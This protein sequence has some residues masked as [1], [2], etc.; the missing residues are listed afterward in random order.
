MVG[1]SNG[2]TNLSAIDLYDPQTGQWYANITQLP[3]PRSFAGITS[4]N[5]KIYVTGGILNDGDVTNKTEVFDIATHSWSNGLNFP[6]EIQGLQLFNQDGRIYS[7]GGSTTNTTEAAISKIMRMDVDAGQWFAIYDIGGTAAPIV[8]LDG[9]A[10]VL[11]G[12]MYYA[13]WRIETG[14]IATTYHQYNYLS[15]FVT[16]AVAT[17]FTA[18]RV[19][20][21]C[22]VYTSG[23]KKYIFYSGGIG[24][25][26]I[27]SQPNTAA[28]VN[29]M[30]VYIPPINTTTIYS[31]GTM[32]TARA[33]HGSVVWGTTL[34]VF[35]G[36]N[37]G[38]T[39][40]S[41][42]YMNTINGVTPETNWPTKTWS[43]GSSSMPNKRFGF[44]A[45]TIY[46]Q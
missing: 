40:D 25:S 46:G 2:T 27:T 43:S 14:G 39:Y 37:A 26:L 23:L 16:N 7:V 30:Y 22:A 19:A 33:Y 36:F 45:V 10:C 41:F 28:A 11:D 31:S 35:G 18:A 8:A 20:A 12:I 34:Y 6:V 15:G 42:E 9:A 5:G 32:N 29:T 21:S 44:Q 38:I 3:T 1:G 13:G 4:A 17:A 24:T